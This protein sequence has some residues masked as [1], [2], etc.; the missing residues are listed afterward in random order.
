MKSVLLIGAAVVAVA[1]QAGI[2]YW[3][4]PEYKAFDVGDYV[5]DGEWTN[6]TW[7][8]GT[9]FTYSAAA[10]LGTVRLTWKP[11]AIG[12]SVILR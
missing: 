4:N 7:H 2:K 3:D 1:G 5:Q 10:N 9:N 6:K 8:D 12:T 11:Q